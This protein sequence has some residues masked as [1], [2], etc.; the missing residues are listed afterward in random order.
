MSA[1]WHKAER[2]AGKIIGCML[3]HTYRHLLHMRKWSQGKF[4]S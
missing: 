4:V 2:Q 1:V 3:E